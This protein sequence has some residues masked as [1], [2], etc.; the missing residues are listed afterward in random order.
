MVTGAG[1]GQQQQ[2]ELSVGAPL[3]RLGPAAD[4][5]TASLADCFCSVCLYTAKYQHRAGYVLLP[6]HS[7]K[8]VLCCAVMKFAVVVRQTAPN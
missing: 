5:P 4:H 8:P 3:C 7:T 6:G 2:H 1:C